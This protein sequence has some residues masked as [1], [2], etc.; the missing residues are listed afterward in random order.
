[1]R[2]LNRAVLILI[3]VAACKKGPKSTLPPLTDA[4]QKPA[5]ETVSTAQSTVI[6]TCWRYSGHAGQAL[7]FYKP[8]APGA[9][10][11]NDSLDDGNWDTSGGLCREGTA[12][13]KDPSK[14]SVLVRTVETNDSTT[15]DVW[16][17]V[18]K[19]Q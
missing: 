4:N 17:N 8:Y 9:K 19:G 10:E 18:P 1:V 13:P 6:D 16:E 12:T 2:Y 14:H 5:G 15:V 3:A 7:A 11:T